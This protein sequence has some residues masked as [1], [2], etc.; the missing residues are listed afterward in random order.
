M[1]TY[2]NRFR[3]QL[4]A[5]SE[6]RTVSV[7]GCVLRGAFGWLRVFPRQ[8]APS[9]GLRRFSVRPT[10]GRRVTTR[11][12]DRSSRRGDPGRSDDM[13]GPGFWFDS[14]RVPGNLDWNEFKV[15][16]REMRVVETV[17][18]TRP[19]LDLT[20]PIGLIGSRVFFY[21]RPWVSFPG[22]QRRSNWT[23]RKNPYPGVL[24]PFHRTKEVPFPR[25]PHDC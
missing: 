20:K 8:P 14:R 6:V 4:V 16:Q 12:D 22:S 25:Q 17:N 10:A 9:S 3:D 18:L 1:S 13:K 23:G 19:E 2:C 24:G 7:S 15:P 11:T 21:W 5:S